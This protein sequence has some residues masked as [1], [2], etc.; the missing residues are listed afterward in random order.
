MPGYA[1]EVIEDARASGHALANSV[2]HW[3]IALLDLS[4]GRPEEAARR[5]LELHRAAPGTAHP[6]FVRMSTPDLVEASIRAGNTED[7]REALPALE[8]FREPSSSAAPCRHRR[9]REM[10]HAAST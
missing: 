9:T 6:Y 10:F 4:L 1:V 7:A 3:G 5:L 8:P 2:A